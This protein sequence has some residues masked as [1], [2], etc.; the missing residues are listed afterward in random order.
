MDAATLERIF[1]PFFTTREVGS[2]SGLG[3]AVVH[4]IVKEH[5]GA[6]TVE[7]RVDH[8]AAFHIHLPAVEAM[9]LTTP[10]ALPTDDSPG[11]GR[12][13]LLLDDEEALVRGET[14]AL[15]RLGYQ[16]TGFTHPSEALEA[17]RD[18]P[19]GF[20]VVV[21]DFD[22]PG[23]SGVEIAVEI[24]QLRP[25]LPVVLVSGLFPEEE[26][27]IA[28]NIRHRLGKP[29]KASELS[30]VLRRLTTAPGWNA[31]TED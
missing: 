6:I 15:T 2:G 20:D 7:S 25:D 16:V 22:M 23:R 4:G 11:R 18:D 27:A 31:S 10:L 8:G 19:S 29:F 30:A 28:P 26:L 3:L 12:R 1:E 9:R 13:V 24:A 17:L 21:T 14:R 5:G